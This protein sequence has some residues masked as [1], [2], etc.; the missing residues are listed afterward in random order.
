MKGFVALHR[1]M[2][3]QLPPRDDRPQICETTIW[4]R[5]HPN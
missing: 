1:G 3:L 2:A 5:P 4:E